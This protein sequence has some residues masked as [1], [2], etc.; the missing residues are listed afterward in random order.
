MLVLIPTLDEG[1]YAG[2]G[3]QSINKLPIWK[4]I[5]WLEIA[6]ALLLVFRDCVHSGTQTVATNW[7]LKVSVRPEAVIRAFRP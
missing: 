4:G 5:C 3:K 7:G 6:V 2:G 1:I